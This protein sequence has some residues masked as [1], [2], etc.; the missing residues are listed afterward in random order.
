M[1]L[2]WKCF[3]FGVQAWKESIRKRG[4]FPIGLKSGKERVDKINFEANVT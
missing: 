3:Q 4:L 2:A 1:Q